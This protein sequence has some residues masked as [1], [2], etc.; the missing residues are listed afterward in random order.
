MR[1]SF[2]QKTARVF[3][4]AG[5]VLTLPAI[6]SLMGAFV[7]M[8]NGVFSAI[9]PILLT[10]ILLFGIAGV[11]FALLFGYYKHSRGTLPAK[12]VP[13]LWGVTLIF[14]GL[15]LVPT[16][17]LFCRE[18]YLSQIKRSPPFEAGLFILGCYVTW[19]AVATFLSGFALAKERK[20]KNNGIFR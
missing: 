18:A 20:I 11:G 15:P 12:S 10:S 8:A 9:S 13:W 3:E 4:I 14:N 2:S 6:L 5:Y 17:L 16:M 7:T 19:L 1:K